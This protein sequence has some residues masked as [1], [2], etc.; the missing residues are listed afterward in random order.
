MSP[1]WPCVRRTYRV[2][3][4]GTLDTYIAL[5]RPVSFIIKARRGGFEEKQI[6]TVAKDDSATRSAK[7]T[8]WSDEIKGRR[9]FAE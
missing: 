5:P 8:T 6:R 9:A 7:S 4:A 2:F 1:K 3:T